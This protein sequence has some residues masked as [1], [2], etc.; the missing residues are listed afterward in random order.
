ME[1]QKKHIDDLFRQQL[2]DYQE[3]PRAGMWD[4]IEDGLDKIDTTKKP[5]NKNTGG[6]RGLLGYSIALLLIAGAAFF[7]F[8][9]SHKQSLQSVAGNKTAVVNKVVT[10]KEGKQIIYLRTD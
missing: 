5:G 7:I 4:R 1:D 10:S 9:Q 8:K 2:N 3:A 6:S